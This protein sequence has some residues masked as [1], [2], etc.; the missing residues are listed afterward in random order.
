MLKKFNY[1]VSRVLMGTKS[2]NEIVNALPYIFF[3]T[4]RHIFAIEIA[5]LITL[6]LRL[7]IG[8]E[9]IKNTTTTPLQLLGTL[10]YLFFFWRIGKYFNKRISISLKVKDRMSIGKSWLLFFIIFL[11]LFSPLI[12]VTWYFITS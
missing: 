5:L 8:E 3:Y 6:L 4:V 2:E 9:S 11:I 12:Y 7:L 10:I 1:F